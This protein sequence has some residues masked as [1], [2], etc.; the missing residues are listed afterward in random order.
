MNFVIFFFLVEVRSDVT[1]GVSSAKM[2]KSFPTV[3]A[4]IEST[5]FAF[6]PFYA[7]YVYN[8]YMYIEIE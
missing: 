4:L 1:K 2:S 5:F 6:S 3:E 7:V 8:V